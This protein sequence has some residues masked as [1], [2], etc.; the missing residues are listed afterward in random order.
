MPDIENTEQLVRA[1][2]E[3]F[4]VNDVTPTTIV[5]EHADRGLRRTGYD[6]MRVTRELLLLRRDR[7]YPNRTPDAM[8]FDFELRENPVRFPQLISSIQR[9][10]ERERFR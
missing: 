2:T 8:K 4:L 1:I 9:A 3:D 7:D 6:Q 10:A 5:D